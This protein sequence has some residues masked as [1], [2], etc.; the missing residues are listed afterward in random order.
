MIKNTENSSESSVF[1]RRRPA[2]VCFAALMQ[3]YS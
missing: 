2:A 3:C 1:L